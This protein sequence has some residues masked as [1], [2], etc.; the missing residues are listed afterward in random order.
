MTEEDRDTQIGRLMR[1]RKEARERLS[2]A[3]ERLQ[4]FK[5]SLAEV[6]DGGQAR[7]G[8]DGSRNLVIDAGRDGVSV[9]ELPTQEQMIDALL[10]V[11]DAEKRVADLEQRVKALGF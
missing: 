5:N 7:V 8:Q 9:I 6:A 11:D 2:Q 3:R 1:E 4:R 10:Q